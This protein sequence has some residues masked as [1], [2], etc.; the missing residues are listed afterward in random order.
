MA[1]VNLILLEDVENLGLAGEEVRVAAGY[2]RNFLVP[3]GKATKATKGAMRQVEAR[4]EQIEAQRKAELEGAEATAAK[5]AEAEVSISMQAS[6]DDTLFGSVG[7]RNI[8]AVLAEQGIEIDYKKILL[9][10]PIKTLGKFDVKVKLHRDVKAEVKV[11]VV[12]R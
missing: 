8:A 9:E 11:W 4:R 1:S 12:R 6:E 10:E 3:K 2:A 7:R 5:L